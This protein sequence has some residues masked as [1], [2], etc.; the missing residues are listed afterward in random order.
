MTKLP[1]RQHK[2]RVSEGAS[3]DFVATNWY[4]VF[5]S[6]SC[7][8]GFLQGYRMGVESGFRTKAEKWDEAKDIAGVIILEAWLK[9]PSSPSPDLSLI[10][11]MSKLKKKKKRRA[12]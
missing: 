8:R 12:N 1:V 5:S 2:P 9:A 4:V 7:L 3:M 6:L 11:K 10:P